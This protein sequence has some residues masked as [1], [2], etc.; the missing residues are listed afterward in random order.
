MESLNQG[1]VLE[2][3]VDAVPF[4]S[5]ND[6]DITTTSKQ[7]IKT[8]TAGKAIYVKKVQLI[9]KTP[10]ETPTIKLQDS[11]GT[12]NEYAKIHVGGIVATGGLQGPVIEHIFDPVLELPVGL[13]FDGIA[14]SAVGDVIVN[15]SG[16]VGT[17]GD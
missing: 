17:P 2:L 8:G 15:A 5:F 1:G 4:H 14:L 16:W 9:N 11:A 12:P 13:D 10:G 7:T 3:P 6:T